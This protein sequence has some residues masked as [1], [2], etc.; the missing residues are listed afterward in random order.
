MASNEGSFV[1]CRVL[2]C[3]AFRLKNRISIYNVCFTKCKHIA[4]A[5]MP[6]IAITRIF[7]RVDLFIP[8][9]I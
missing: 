9:K 3:L 6:Y 8:T 7:F 4:K 1:N 2:T 5:M